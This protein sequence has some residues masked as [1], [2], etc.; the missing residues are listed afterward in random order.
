MNAAAD[1]T[2]SAA[3]ATSWLNDTHTVT[4]LSLQYVSMLTVAIAGAL[5]T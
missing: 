5:L 2:F 1:S 4:G 3:I